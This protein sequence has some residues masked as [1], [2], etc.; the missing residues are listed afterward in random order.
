MKN[1]LLFSPKKSIVPGGKIDILWRKICI[2][3]RLADQNYRVLFKEGVNQSYR[4]FLANK[5]GVKTVSVSKLV[6]WTRLNLRLLS[7]T[8]N[9]GQTSH[10][11]LLCILALTLEHLKKGQNFLEIGTYDG[12]TAFNVASNLPI[13]SQV[14]TIDLPELTDQNVKE[15]YDNYL[16][17][18]PKRS[19]KKHLHLKNVKQIYSDS[20]K[21]DF[22]KFKFSVAFIDGGHDFETVK[23][24]TVNCLN[25]ISTPGIIIWHDYDVECE[26]GD[27]LHY[28]ANYYSICQIEGTRLA[29]LKV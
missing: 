15:P 5:F 8:Q 26:I 11:E 9:D 3:G 13:G 18:N 6:D 1:L 19:N 14:I 4:K 22:S 2:L 23:S 16:V 28:M 24:D 29:F 27:L 10:L 21:L 12:N 17:H 7:P 25:N 20:T